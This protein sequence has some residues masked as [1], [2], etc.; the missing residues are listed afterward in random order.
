M[1]VLLVN[2]PHKEWPYLNEEDN[3]LL[4][5]WLPCLGAVL[6]ENDVEVELLDCMPIKMGWK[7]LEKRVR[8]VK[9]DVIGTGSSETLYSNE[10]LKLVHLAKEIDP[11]ITTVLGGAHFSHLV[12]RTLKKHPVDF[13]VI[14][15]GE[16]TIVEL[17]K[18]LENGGEDFEKIK[19][20]AFE[21]D[22]EVVK[23]KPRPLI[24][25]LDELPTPAYDLLPMEKYGQ[26]RYL[27]HPGGTTIHHSRGCTANCDFCICWKQM[28]ERNKEEDFVKCSPKW[29]SKSVEKT[30]D[31]LE[32]LYEKFDKRGFVFTDDTWNA[33]PRWSE[34]F[35][36]GVMDR[37]LDIN[38]FAFMRAD[39]L[40]RDEEMGVLEK[41]VDSGLSHV[42]IGVERKFD[43]NLKLLNKDYTRERTKRCFEILKNKY[44]GVFRQGTFIVGLRNETKETMLEQLDFAEELDLDYPAFHPLTP[45]PGTEIWERAKQEDW[46]EIEDF[47]AFDWLTPVMS[48]KNLSREEI[49]RILIKMNNTYMSP[50]KALKGLVSPHKYRR[51]M[52]KWFLWVT[53]KLLL[54]RFKKKINP[55]QKEEDGGSG[56]VKLKKPNWYDS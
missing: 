19:G 32:L 16:R 50:K 13:I 56:I 10:A 1:K 54:D 26:S 36:E 20:L 30:L 37:G 46:L 22:N 24:E 2:P 48:S 53:L 31:E 40:V 45:V 3:Y 29:R 27:F 55:W 14:G 21:K 35:A 49:E 11:E 23:T 25:D 51:K 17:V 12:D 52:Y 9:P 42:C 28:S 34:N 7:S 8:E 41:L 6:R 38:W 43:E 18:T 44:P 33:D 5:Q 15:E 4:P 39:F 47:E